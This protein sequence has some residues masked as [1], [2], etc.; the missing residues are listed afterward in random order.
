MTKLAW[1]GDAFFSQK[2]VAHLAGARPS[3]PQCIKHVS[4]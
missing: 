4:G 2:E 1:W 3:L